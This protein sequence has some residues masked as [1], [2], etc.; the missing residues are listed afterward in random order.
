LRA[1]ILAQ[2]RRCE[3]LIVLADRLP[4]VVQG[5]DKPA[6]VSEV[7]EFAELCGIRGKFATVAQLY[8]DALETSPQLAADLRSTDRYRAACA[9]ALAGCGRGDGADLEP[10]YRARWRE[11]ACEWLRAEV[12]LWASALDGGPQA[13]RVVVRDKL[14]HLWFD[15]D[16]DGLLN[17]QLSDEL[18][19]AERQKCRALW[20]DIDALI[21]RAQTIE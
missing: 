13:D 7:L 20:G 21:L 17:P 11:Q 2:L 1:N 3:R 18:S 15:P 14:T 12:T 10:A 9:A 4:A 5:K 16:L 6:D 8:V 19:P